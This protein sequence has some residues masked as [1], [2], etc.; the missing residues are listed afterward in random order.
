MLSFVLQS[1]ELRK[2]NHSE[3]LIAYE[4]L[5]GTKSYKLSKSL[6]TV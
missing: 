5:W 6:D 3:D 4:N 2:N 1:L